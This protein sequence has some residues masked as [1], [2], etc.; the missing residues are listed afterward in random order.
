MD[1]FFRLVMCFIT[2]IIA[3]SFWETKTPFNFAVLVICICAFFFLVV[4][5]ARKGKGE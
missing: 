4:D 1:Y 2:G 3:F 5:D